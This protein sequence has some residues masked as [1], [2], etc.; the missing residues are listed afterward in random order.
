MT[1]IPSVVQLA[2]GDLPEGWDIQKLKFFATIRTSNVDKTVSDDEIPVELCNYTDVYYNDRIVPSMEFMRGSA[3]AAEIR[4]FR[5]QFGQVIITKDSEGWDDIGI[6]ALVTEDMPGVLCGY[7]LAIFDPTNKLDGNYLSWLCRSAPL[8]NQFK[9]AANGVTRFGLG[10][11]AMKNAYIALPPIKT[12]RRIAAFLDEKT[13]RIDA[14]IEKKRALLD[15][16]AEKRQALITQTVTKGLD[17]GVQMKPSGLNWLGEIPEHWNVRRLRFF[18]ACRTINGLYKPKE[19]FDN[20]GVPFIQ[21]GEA[22]RS[23]SFQG[24]TEDRVLA[25][26]DEVKQWG[27]HEGDFLIA[28]RSLV[29][30]GSGKSVRIE[31]ISEPHLFESSMI[32]LRIKNPEKYSRFLSYYFQSQVGRAFFLA[33]TKQ[34]TISGIDSQQLK[35]IP[36]LLPPAKEAHDISNF[37]MDA[38]RRFGEIVQRIETSV[39]RLKE[40]RS[41]LITTVVNGE[42]LPN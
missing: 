38:E 22:F 42:S 11:H 39:V 5:L 24:G 35:N 1:A 3:T 12:Q 2:Y 13:A 14:L 21:M 33:I 30:D 41:A 40:Y 28:R 8:N 6:P 36:T 26:E 37:L 9:T 16:L 17:A 34:V 20:S 27:L 25:T 23:E 29:F 10:Q 7:H 32:R 4:K 18:M 31:S 15:R 19:Q